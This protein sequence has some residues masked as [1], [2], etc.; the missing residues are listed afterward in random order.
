VPGPSPAPAAP[1]GAGIAGESPTGG[2][3]GPAASE[4]GAGR[5]ARPAG[6]ETS[7]AAADTGGRPSGPRTGSGQAERGP[8]AGSG[9]GANAA[10]KGAV[11]RPAAGN[12]A[13]PGKS[14]PPGA[15]FSQTLALS[16]SAPERT[17]ART[18]SP[19]EG[20]P[21]KAGVRHAGH[22]NK[23]DPVAVALALM[24]R[25]GS[26]PPPHAEVRTS[27]PDHAGK[28]AVDP[29][30]VAQAGQS[31]DAAAHA[32]TAAV[33]AALEE[34]V[35]GATAAAGHSGA[36]P[37]AGQPNGAGP[38]TAAQLV[39]SAQ[40]SAG[41][42]SG[43]AGGPALTAPVGSGAW[44]EQLAAR[45]TWMTQQGVQSASLQLSPR[46]LGPLQVSISVQH[47]QA[48]VWFGAA[49]PETRQALARALPELRNLFAN[50]GLSL[51]DS[52]VSRDAPRQARAGAGGAVTAGAETPG[53][54]SELSGAVAALR[55][56][57]LIDTY[58]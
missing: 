8:P 26:A 53:T 6:A 18:A 12:S 20:K 44:T 22:G 25:A 46:N 34:S 9:G 21:A 52:G 27:A 23:T 58:A 41:G 56:A 35:A 17:A 5:T 51:T 31:A 39:A 3:G 29:V 2:A 57:G 43:S 55:G 37:G 7:N 42:L 11:G 28:P 33:H 36:A 1:L 13:Q 38:L 14:A 49:Q 30:V 54:H 40:A 47:G 45:L 16:L 50:Q 10:H 19:P 15:D 32:V 24:D 48:S 4:G